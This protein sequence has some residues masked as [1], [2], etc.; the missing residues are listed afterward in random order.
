MA[1]F[2]PLFVPKSLCL[3]GSAHSVSCSDVVA[4]RSKIQF[5]ES[6]LS[7]RLETAIGLKIVPAIDGGAYA[8]DTGEGLIWYV[9][10]DKAVRVSGLEGSE[11]ETMA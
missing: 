7:R 3:D 8:I 11:Y 5:H 1:K 2:R 4:P 6:P 10:E 9:R